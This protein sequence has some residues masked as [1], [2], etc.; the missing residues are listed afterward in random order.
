MNINLFGLAKGDPSVAGGIQG[1]NLYIEGTMRALFSLLF[2]VG[3][4]V[5]TDRLEKQ[6]G[7]IEVANI[8]FRRTL[9]LI[10]FGLLHAYLLLW[11]SEILFDYGLMGLLLFLFA[12]LLLP[13]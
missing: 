2:G 3:M 5:L 9:W 10:L 6:G 11:Y 8:Y 13:S 7:S 1:W 4:F 12:I